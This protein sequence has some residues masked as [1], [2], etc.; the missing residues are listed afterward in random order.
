MKQQGVDR[1]A[2]IAAAAARHASATRTTLPASARP[3]RPRRLRKRGAGLRTPESKERNRER[4]QGSY[5]ERRAA[6]LCHICGKPSPD[7]SA[8]DAC[9]ADRARAKARRREA[10]I[11]AGLCPACGEPAA[12]GGR[13]CS[14]HRAA[15]RERARRERGYQGPPEPRRYRGPQP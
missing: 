12:P 11:A 9:R 13:L 2:L 8:C 1:L 3:T 5:A 6:G 15:T 10:R 14:H 7:K 4:M